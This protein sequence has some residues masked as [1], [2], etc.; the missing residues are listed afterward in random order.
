MRRFAGRTD[1]SNVAFRGSTPDPTTAIQAVAGSGVD[2][3]P[4]RGTRSINKRN[5]L[6]VD[7]QQRQAV[8]LR[9][10]GNQSEDKSKTGLG[11]LAVTIRAPVT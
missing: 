10:P 1:A 4:V 11:D 3:G 5:F 2:A 7:R 8:Q 6:N 9:Q